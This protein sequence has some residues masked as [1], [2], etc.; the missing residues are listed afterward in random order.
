MKIITS[1]RHFDM[2]EAI[3]LYTD[4]KLAAMLP[5]SFRVTSVR[6]VMTLEKNRFRTDI[7]VLLPDHDLNSLAEDF[8]LYKSFDAALEKVVAQVERVVGKGHNHNAPPMREVAG[9]EAAKQD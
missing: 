8:D 9:E 4:G 3:R 5:E 2:T 1:S 7:Q 6:A